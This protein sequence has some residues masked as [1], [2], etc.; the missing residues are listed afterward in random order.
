MPGAFSLTNLEVTK[1]ATAKSQISTIGDEPVVVEPVATVSPGVT[2]PIGD[3]EYITIH[4]SGEDGGTD[5]VFVGLDG[6]AYQI[7]RDKPF[8][9]PKGVS[10]ILR[11]AVT[12]S[13]KAGPGGAVT[14]R[15]TPR[16]VFTT[17]AA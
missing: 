14:E 3:K 7:P 15:T 10:Q 12:T 16:Y 13:Y 8:L 1:M 9:V 2:A 17:Q 4:S 11:D 5:A 6:Y